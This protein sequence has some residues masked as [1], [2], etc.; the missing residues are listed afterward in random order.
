MAE[1][2]TYFCKHVWDIVIPHEAQTE[3]DATIVGGRWLLCNN[4]VTVNQT[5]RGGY[6]ATEVNHQDESP[7]IASTPPSGGCQMSVQ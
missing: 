7:H 6:A 1:E 3:K 2:I 4:G 5:V